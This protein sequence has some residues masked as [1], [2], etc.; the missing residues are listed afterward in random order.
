MKVVV[1]TNVFRCGAFGPKLVY[2]KRE[3]LTEAAQC[4]HGFLLTQE[5]TVR[6]VR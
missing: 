6:N 3:L 4:K 2:N 1:D 5:V